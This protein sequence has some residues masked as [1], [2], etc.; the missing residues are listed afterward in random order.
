MFIIKTEEINLGD[1][2]E[3]YYNTDTEN[4]ISTKVNYKRF[5]INGKTYETFGM[6]WENCNV[7]E[8]EITYYNYILT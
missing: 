3:I 2:G 1:N 6:Q 8:E 5:Q 7:P 4:V